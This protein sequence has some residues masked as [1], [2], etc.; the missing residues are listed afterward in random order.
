VIAVVILLRVLARIFYSLKYNL[1]PRVSPTRPYG[2][3][4]GRRENL[5]TRLSKID[6]PTPESFNV[7][8]FNTKVSTLISFEEG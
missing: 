4:E 3:R 2:A 8:F 6:A 5:G 7:L 1:V